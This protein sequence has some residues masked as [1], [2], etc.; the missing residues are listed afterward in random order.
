MKPML[1]SLVFTAGLLAAS[2]VQALTLLPYDAAAVAKAQAA[3]EPLALHFHAG[4]CPVCRAQDKS[5]EALK[6]E[7]GLDIKVF[8]VDYDQETEL[9]K[10]L[11]VR[12]QSTFIVYRGREEKARMSGITATDDIS[13]TLRAA[14]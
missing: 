11:K 6:A 13:L 14:L 10:Q 1:R 8:K 9:K 5:L 2:L 4:W 3:G 7:P 12:Q